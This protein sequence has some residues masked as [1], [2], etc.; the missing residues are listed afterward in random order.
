MLDAREMIL[1][2]PSQALLIK[3]EYDKAVSLCE[4]AIETEP[5]AMNHYWY[6][7]LAYLLQGQEEAAQTTWLLAMSQATPE[8]MEQWAQELSQILDS[9]AQRQAELDNHQTAWLIRQHLR[10]ILPNE[11]NNILNLLL[12]S[13]T[14]GSFTPEL[15]QDWQVAELLEQSSLEVINT[16]LLLQVLKQVLEFPAE[17]T[18]AFVAACL[19]LNE[20]FI[21][22][23]VSVA[24]KIAYQH[25]QQGFA[26]KLAEL[27]LKFNPE[28]P[29]VL[30]HLSC[31][32]T[33]SG[34]Y[35][36]G[37]EAAKQF[38]NRCQTYDWQVLGNYLILRALLTAAA[39][40]EVGEVAQRH[41]LLLSQVIQE[42][43]DNLDRGGNLAMIIAP[44]FLPYLHN[45]L[46]KNRWF[47]NQ[48][49]QIFQKNVHSL[50]PASVQLNYSN[51]KQTT[52]SLRIG[53]VGYTFRVHSVGWLCRWL[54]EYY[55]RESFTINI[56]CLNQN[57]EDRFTQTWFADKVN[58]IYSFELNTAPAIAEQIRKDEI[59]ILVDLD[60]ITLDT[61]CELMALKPAPVQVAWLGWDSSGIP[62]IDYF[63][64]DPYVLP[65]DAQDYYQETIWRLP[66][67]YV[68]VDGFEV[69]TPT[70]RRDD[71]EIPPGAVVYLSAQSGYK[72]HPDTIRLQLQIIKQVP[73]SYFLIKGV[74]D[75][76]AIQ[77]SFTQ[78][79]AEVGVDLERLK[80]L[81]RDPNEIV[82]RANL[83]IAD[84]VLDTYPFNGATTTLETLWMGIPIVTRVGQQFAA[85]N[86][87][88]FMMNV[89]VTEGIAWT[90]EEYVEWG[91]RLGKDASLR[92]QIAWKL[93][94]SR[95]TSPLWNAKQFTQEMEKAYKQMWQRYSCLSLSPS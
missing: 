39:W 91:V 11:V 19:P 63:I 90:D 75:E 71:L 68:A 55:D 14:I 49:G 86:S 51:L 17:A 60:S 25:A 1:Q 88:A 47:Q 34:D 22:I 40:R 33:N 15:L 70:L 30:Q 23:V 16:D 46:Q 2:H 31:F 8:N 92:Q 66:Q 82:H 85:R 95:Q 74:A 18:L 52:R 93:R 72:R 76:S 54:F 67:T 26:A 29:G 77:E 61:T 20:I 56:Y 69:A 48:I 37:I 57:L 84:V 42:Q 64:A 38:Y 28:Y 83:A 65:E 3:G 21:G 6:S 50:H 94:Q 35:Q 79:A 73:N 58:A 32:Y 27:C 10:E 12:L 7:G 43:P 36:R 24:V 59:D 87:Y 81:P 62:A 89:G 53:Y 44:F 78:I 4:Q 41:E 45:N 5:D 80:F 9:E 13:L